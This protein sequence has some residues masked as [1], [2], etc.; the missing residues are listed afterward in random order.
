MYEISSQRGHPLRV[1]KNYK[2]RF[3]RNVSQGSVW[4]CTSKNCNAKIIFDE[5][6][7]VKFEKNIH[8]H[9]PNFKKSFKNHNMGTI[10]SLKEQNTKS[11]SETGSVQEEKN[12]KN[13][14]DIVDEKMSRKTN[15]TSR[16][17]FLPIENFTNCDEQDESSIET[18]R[19]CIRRKYQVL[20]QM[21]RSQNQFEHNKK[22]I[23][24][25]NSKHHVTGQPHVVL[26]NDDITTS[27]KLN[28]ETENHNHHQHYHT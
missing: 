9:S 24:V 25:N 28:S 10:Y 23:S 11:T 26:E 22:S 16:C 2:F 3:L 14:D 8:Y 1:I 13:N 19:E 12:H 15:N 27:L 21:K 4:R 20:Q 18:I 17:L 5:N 7:Q 6:H